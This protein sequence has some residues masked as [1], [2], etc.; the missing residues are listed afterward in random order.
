MAFGTAGAAGYFSI[1][2]IVLGSLGILSVLLLR[3]LPA[4]I[5]ERC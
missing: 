1:S 5:R 4:T 2:F 3:S